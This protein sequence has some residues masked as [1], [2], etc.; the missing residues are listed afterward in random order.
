MLIAAEYHNVAI[1]FKMSSPCFARKQL[2]TESGRAFDG[3]VGIFKTAQTH[4]NVF[5][6]LQFYL[7]NIHREE[8]FRH[9]TLTD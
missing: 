8:L 7:L 4:S 2:Q 6:F 3:K 1:I 5:L 9:D